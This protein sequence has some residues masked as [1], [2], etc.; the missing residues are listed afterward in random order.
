[1]GARGTKPQPTAIKK[2]RGTRKD[3]INLDE[4][5]P[6]SLSV[7]TPPPDRFKKHVRQKQ[8]WVYFLKLFSEMR[9][10]SVADQAAM[11]ELVYHKWMSERAEEEVRLKGEVIVQVNKAKQEYYIENPWLNIKYKSS[12]RVTKLLTQ[13]GLTPSSRSSVKVEKPSVKKT[14]LKI[15]MVKK[16]SA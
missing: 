10:L 15:L 3:R 1:M 11:E 2:A 12:D 5:E 9:I 7:S 16:K 13:F 14:G 8:L 6:P 4:P